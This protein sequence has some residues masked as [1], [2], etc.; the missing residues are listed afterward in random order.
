ME[1]FGLELLG[2]ELPFESV[3]MFLGSFRLGTFGWDLQFESV[4]LLGASV[5]EL[6]FGSFWLGVSI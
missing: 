5:W 2:W 4:E 1:A 3:G 6:S